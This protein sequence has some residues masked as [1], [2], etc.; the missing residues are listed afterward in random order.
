MGVRPTCALRSPDHGARSGRTTTLPALVYHIQASLSSGKCKNDVLLLSDT[1]KAP[2]PLRPPHPVLESIVGRASPSS[3]RRPRCG[4]GI[5]AP[6]PRLQA[7][8]SHPSPSSS[9]C[10]AWGTR[11]REERTPNTPRKSGAAKGP[12]PADARS[13]LVPSVPFVPYVPSTGPGAPPRPRTPSPRTPTTAPR[14]PK[15]QRRGQQVGS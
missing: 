7:R 4:R 10:P 5:P 11:Q 1:L 3:A 6:H 2:Q 9:P 8:P 14:T 15:Q 12:A 13:A